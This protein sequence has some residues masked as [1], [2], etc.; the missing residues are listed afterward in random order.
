MAELFS[1]KAIILKGRDYGESD[2]VITLLLM[3]KGKINVI[4]KGAKK[5]KKRF[6]NSLELFSLI[7]ANIRDYRADRFP[8]IE[9]C[10]VITA[11]DQI[12]VEPIR[13]SCAALCCE[14]VDL[15]LK[16]L[17]PDNEVFFLLLWVLD[18][19]NC[20]A[21]PYGAVL[22]FKVKLLALVGYAQDWHKVSDELK[23]GLNAG[24]IR[25]LEYIQNSDMERLKRLRFSRQ[26]MRQAWLAAKA[27]HIRYLAKEPCSYG[28]LR[29]LS[30]ISK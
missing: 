4:A 22:F 28:V 3:D 16:E 30:A 15:W 1:S 10:S 2:R 14:F 24:T 9:S 18:A 6:L 5:S 29:Q 12:R 13:Y 21:E 11:F 19:L 23:I 25:S 27:L 26:S 20:G 17:L 7:Y 8:I